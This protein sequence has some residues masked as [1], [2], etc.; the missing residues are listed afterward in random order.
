MKRCWTAEKTMGGQ[1]LRQN[2]QIKAYIE[3]DDDWHIHTLFWQHGSDWKYWAGW[4]MAHVIMHLTYIK[5]VTSL[6]LGWDTS[7]PDWDFSWFSS[8]LPDRCWDSISRSVM[9]AS[10]LIFQF[11]THLIS[12][13]SCYIVSVIDDRVVNKLQIKFKKEHKKVFTCNVIIWKWTQT[14]Y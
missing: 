9:T 10:V 11:I 4:R 1:S 13:I 8:V 2:R 5:E 14:Q 12:V 3:V 6:K 7:Y